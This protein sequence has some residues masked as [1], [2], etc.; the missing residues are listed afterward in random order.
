MF[1]Q[2][3]PITKNLLIINAAGVPAVCVRFCR[4]KYAD[5]AL[6]AGGIC[7]K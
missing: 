4:G 1:R 7:G 6:T 5:S 3:P 2:I